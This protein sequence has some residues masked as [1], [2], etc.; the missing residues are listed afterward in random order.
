MQ[1]ATPLCLFTGRVEKQNREYV[2]TIPDQ[3]IDLGTLQ[4][5]ETYRI[6]VYATASAP[7]GTSAHQPDPTAEN[8]NNPTH[9]PTPSRDCKSP[10]TAASSAARPPRPTRT[11]TSYRCVKARRSRSTSKV[12]ASRAMASPKS[13]RDTSCSSPIPKSASNHSSGS[14][15]PARTS[16]SPRSLTSKCHATTS[17]RA[18][19]RVSVAALAVPSRSRGGRTGQSNDEPAS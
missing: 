9:R 19:E 3:E 5:D 13:A 1:S 17:V 4:S 15:P 14:L 10:E 7:S 8:A 2:L 18:S 16:P 12:W 6:G 11:P